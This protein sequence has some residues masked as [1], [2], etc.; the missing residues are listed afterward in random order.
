[1]LKSLLYRAIDLVGSLPR[2]R[3]SY[4]IIDRARAYLYNH[5]MSA[6]LPWLCDYCGYRIRKGEEHNYCEHELYSI[7]PDKYRMPE[8]VALDSFCSHYGCW[9]EFAN[10]LTHD[11]CPDC[12]QHN[13]ICGGL[14]KII[15][16]EDDLGGLDD[17][18]DE[19]V[20]TS[21]I[22][23]RAYAHFGNSEMAREATEMYPGDFM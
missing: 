10:C 19:P 9:G 15:E 22:Y 21:V 6:N 20:S 18:D 1:M 2:N 14:C 4:L 12:G 16:S 17:D 13:I 5:A 7:N 3:Y 11:H 8:D 23:G